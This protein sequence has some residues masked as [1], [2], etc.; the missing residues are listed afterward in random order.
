MQ[1]CILLHWRA[2]HSGGLSL[3]TSNRMLYLA[4]NYTF[5]WHLKLA[6]SGFFLEGKVKGRV[7]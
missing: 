2:P 3:V 1:S 7:R 6:V 4:L 5:S